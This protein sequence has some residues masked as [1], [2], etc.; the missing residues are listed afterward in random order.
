MLAVKF[1]TQIRRLG[2]GEHTRNYLPTFAAAILVISSSLTT[3]GSSKAQSAGAFDK[4]IKKVTVHFLTTPTPDE[5]KIP[6][7]VSCY[8][9]PDLLIKKYYQQGDC[10]GGVSFLRSRGKLPAC[11]PSHQPGEQFMGVLGGPDEASDDFDG[12]KGNLVFIDF[13]ENEQGAVPFA[14]YDS[15]TGKKIFQDS[16]TSPRLR[17]FST[18]AGAL[19]KYVR[20]I[21]AG[22][23]LHAPDKKEAC[24]EKVKVKLGLKSNPM[25]VCTNYPQTLKFFNT[26]YDV[27][28][29]AYPV[30]VTLSPHPVIKPVDGPSKCW[31]TY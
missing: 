27:A 15:T 30:E 9:Y 10:G 6:S 3:Y 5:P 20:A 28:M 11:K 31:P 1:A 14:I 4:P 22:C 19:V 16:T 21:N 29:F 12:V 13:C 8:Y 2:A 25:P 18:K 7:T 24:W 17:V 26:Q 23:D